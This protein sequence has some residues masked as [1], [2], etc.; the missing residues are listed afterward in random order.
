MNI[1]KQTAPRASASESDDGLHAANIAQDLPA[2]QF[3]CNMSY[4]E[5]SN[6]MNED[7]GL[8]SEI[9]DGQKV[10]LAHAVAETDGNEAMDRGPFT[11]ADRRRAM[12][13]DD[14]GKRVLPIVR[15]AVDAF[16]AD[17]NEA[18]RGRDLPF[19]IALVEDQSNSKAD[20]LAT[21]FVYYLWPGTTIETRLLSWDG[22]RKPLDASGRLRIAVRDDEERTMRVRVESELGGR[23]PVRLRYEFPDVATMRPDRD[24]IVSVLTQALVHYV[25]FGKEFHDYKTKERVLVPILSRCI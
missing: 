3:R 11:E 13:I 5:G 1:G 24:A 4:F 6:I 8:M 25:R 17:F 15:G 21:L 7:E 22:Q 23:L 16:T 9:S 12:M 14:V 20:T 18:Y 10:N 2:W 19:E